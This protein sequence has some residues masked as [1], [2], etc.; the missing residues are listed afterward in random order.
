MS[1]KVWLQA[2]SVRV[3]AGTLFLF[4]LKK[5]PIFGTILVKEKEQ[6]EITKWFLK[7]IFKTRICYICLYPLAKGSYTA[8]K[9]VSEIGYTRLAQRGGLNGGKIV[10]ISSSKYVQVWKQGG[11]CQHSPTQE[12]HSNTYSSETSQFPAENV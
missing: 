2:W 11:C 7:L 4:S 1:T 9:Y 10:S 8:R 3:Q 12:I 5:Q 6:N